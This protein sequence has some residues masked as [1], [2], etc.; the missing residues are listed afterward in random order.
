MSD[1]DFKKLT[2]PFPEEE[3][4][5]RVAR[6]GKDRNGKVWAKVLAYVT[7]R[8]IQDRLDSVFGPE[9]W[10]VSYRVLGAGQQGDDI[11]SGIIC[12]LAVRIGEA[13]VA[14]EDG[15]EQSDIES[16]KGGLSSAIKRAAVAWG[17]GRYLYGLEEGYADIVEKGG[18][19]G[20]L[21]DK[22]GGDVFHW[23][24]PRLPAWALPALRNKAAVG[25]GSPRHDQL[26][27]TGESVRKDDISIPKA[28]AREAQDIND[29]IKKRHGASWGTDIALA[30]MR[31]AYGVT[32]IGDLTETQANE[33][34]V[35]IME[36]SPTTALEWLKIK[37]RGKTA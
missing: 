33:L 22:Q 15:A 11:T 16:F 14:K 23:L 1:Y 18:R 26:P 5:W 24:P 35:V 12:S 3:I 32:K 20:K 27:S 6:A 13:W 7:A 21:P 31:Q 8:A 2:D 34:I 37:Q 36:K 29:A 9:N 17:I 25:D 10:R 28:G 30:Y 4:E 19:Y